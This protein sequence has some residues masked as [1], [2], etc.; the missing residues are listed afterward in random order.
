MLFYNKGER[1][2]ALGLQSIQFMILIVIIWRQVYLLRIAGIIFG[3]ASAHAV[4]TLPP[5]Q[6]AS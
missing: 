4:R 2:E 3:A 5:R 6:A 1:L